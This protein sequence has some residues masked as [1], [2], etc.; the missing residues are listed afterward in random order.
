[1]RRI[2]GLMKL[3]LY[4]LYLSVRIV[5]IAFFYGFAKDRQ[6]QQ[7]KAN[8]LYDRIQRK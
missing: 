7:D 6:K 8:V 4:N 1:M 2:E 3:N 5:G